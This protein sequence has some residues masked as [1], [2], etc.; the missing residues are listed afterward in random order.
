MPSMPW[1]DQDPSNCSVTLALDVVGKPWILLVLREVF[2]G[3]NRFDEIQRHIGVSPPVLS[4]RL[5][6]MVDAGL[7][8]RV[9]YR[10]EGSRER[11]EYHL[12]DSGRALFPVLLALR[13]WGDAHLAGTNGPATVYRHEDCGA[14]VRVAMFCADG[15][16]LASRADVVPEPGPGARPLT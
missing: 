7:L 1:A 6:A 9:P 5:T 16:Q 4:R 12:T 10:E 2:R 3:L 11:S 14:E 13:D 8:E 15:H